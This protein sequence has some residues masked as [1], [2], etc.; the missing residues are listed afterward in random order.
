MRRS[1]NRW[2]LAQQMVDELLREHHWIARSIE[3]AVRPERA[4]RRRWLWRPDGAHRPASLGRLP[5][6]GSRSRGPAV[7]TADR[8]AHGLRS[9]WSASRWQ[10]LIV[11]SGHATRRPDSTASCCRPLRASDRPS[12]VTMIR[13]CP[14]LAVPHRTPVVHGRRW[15]IRCTAVAETEVTLP[16]PSHRAAHRRLVQH[17]GAVSRVAP[18]RLL[19]ERGGLPD[20]RCGGRS[21]RA[22]ASGRASTAT[23]SPSWNSAT[24]PTS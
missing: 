2:R 7:L 24:K 21:L 22:P 5:S 23:S 13:H 3:R 8:G 14:L 17:D 19:A 10:C 18:S 20:D 16:G 6:G 15:R 12:R 11:R 4:A 9:C 1:T